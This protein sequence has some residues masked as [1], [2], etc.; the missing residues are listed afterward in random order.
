MPYFNEKYNLW[1]GRVQFKRKRTA[2]NFATKSKAEKWE[3][4][5]RQELWRPYVSKA[6]EM[7]ARGEHRDEIEKIFKDD[8]NINLKDC[9]VPTKPIPR[10]QREI[11]PEFGVSQQ[12][13]QSTILPRAYKKY[14]LEFKRYYGWN[15]STECDVCGYRNLNKFVHEY[16]NDYDGLDEI[17]LPE[18]WR[19]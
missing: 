12:Y 17:E 1:E 11:A 15:K 19:Y 13:L 18:Q 6:L 14:R 10:T 4:D 2:K 3:C 8:L 5:V 16:H 9:L 7:Y